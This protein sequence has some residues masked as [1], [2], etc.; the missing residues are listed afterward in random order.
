MS[1]MSPGAALPTFALKA[2]LAHHLI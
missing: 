2:R 1:K